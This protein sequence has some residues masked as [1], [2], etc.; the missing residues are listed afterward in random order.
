MSGS[1]AMKASRKLGASHGRASPAIETF[2]ER[3]QL[4]LNPSPNPGFTGLHRDIRFMANAVHA[5]TPERYD[6]DGPCDLSYRPPGLGE[7]IDVVWI[8]G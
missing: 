2:N 7:M 8:S 4:E 3:P 6:D 1:L 5:V